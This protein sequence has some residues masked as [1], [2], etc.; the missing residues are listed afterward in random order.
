MV[1]LLLAD[2][3]LFSP[4]IKRPLLPARP[5]EWL[6]CINCCT[7]YV[8][9]LLTRKLV[10]L[11]RHLC[12]RLQRISRTRCI[13][14]DRKV[15][16]VEPAK[17]ADGEVINPLASWGTNFTTP[18]SSRKDQEAPVAGSSG[19]IAP[20]RKRS[21]E[22]AHRVLDILSSLSGGSSDEGAN[23]LKTRMI[24]DG[25]YISMALVGGALLL[26]AS[27]AARYVCRRSTSTEDLSDRPRKQKR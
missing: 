14:S 26:G 20:G 12:A 8:T 6:A 19:F 1:Q 18:D 2:T 4:T 16:L 17:N 7:S 9:N 24:T 27:N 23:G 3:F 22:P 10:N 25:P 5:K 13:T 15:K 21:V 11:P